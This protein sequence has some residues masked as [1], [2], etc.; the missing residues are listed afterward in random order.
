MENPLCEMLV[1]KYNDMHVRVCMVDSAAQ[2]LLQV[3]QFHL[4]LG[5]AWPVF[6]ISNK[7]ASDYCYDDHTYGC[8]IGPYFLFCM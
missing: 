8:Q 4:P 3:L 5:C 1:C 6:P 2:P 7:C